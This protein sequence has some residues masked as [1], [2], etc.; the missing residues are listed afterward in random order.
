M[1]I[2][3]NTVPSSF[4]ITTRWT[5]RFADRSIIPGIIALILGLILCIAAAET[6]VNV[7]IIFVIPFL[8]VV[9]AAVI[10]ARYP[11]S[12]VMI[13]MLF[14]PFVA[15]GTS[16]Y[17]VP[18]YYAV[19]RGMIVATLAVVIVKSWMAESK[20]PKIRFGLAE[21]VMVIA[22]LWSIGSIYILG[23]SHL[24]N[25]V[26]LYDRILVPYCM[27][28]L[29]R[30]S[31]P[32]AED[33]K[34][35]LPAAFITMMAQAAIGLASWFTPGILPKQWLGEAGQ[36]VVGTFKNPAVYTTTVMFLGLLLF[37]YFYNSKSAWR[38]TFGILIL[39]LAFVCDL[40]SFSRGSW[41]GGGLVLLGLTIVYPRLMLRFEI[42]VLMLGIALGT[43]VLTHEIDFAIQRLND[44]ETV[45]SRLL[46]GAKSLGMIEQKPL[47]GWG[48][49]NYDRY[50]DAFRITT[51]NPAS[52]KESDHTSHNTFFT[53]A[54]EQG[55]PAVVWYLF[56]T[57]W[58][59]LTTL[60]VW[61]RLPASGFWSRTLLVLLWLLI[62]DH[63]AVSS[64]MD[65]IRFNLFGTTI[66]WM[67]LGLIANFVTTAK[68][69]PQTQ[70]VPIKAIN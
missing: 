23:Q 9:P 69:E 21:F 19:H 28:W 14:F 4:Q 36:R 30:L 20:R 42:I 1:A 33:L 6:A 17:M 54:A 63:L 12:A 27:Y 18:I 47:F 66:Y 50:D 25:M 51:I 56:P 45:Q 37:Q 32:T 5:D 46:T 60:A 67:A 55:I 58:W 3:E 52:I 65:M 22:V 38:R 29:I 40:I 35:L 61:K 39:G 64:F 44:A 68:Q 57:L 49:G 2:Q 16:G 7:G 15:R 59:F 13:W 8:V 10:L 70:S 41:V 48:F 62:L 26:D 31:A 24:G 43:T 53:V 11:L 34:R